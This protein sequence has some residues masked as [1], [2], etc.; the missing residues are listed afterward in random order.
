MLVS[1]ELYL[2]E[3]DF[4]SQH[5]S[6]CDLLIK[7]TGTQ[8]IYAI[9][10]QLHDRIKILA[11]HRIQNTDEL[12]ALLDSDALFNY[13][14]RKVK[15]ALYTKKFTFIPHEVY[16]VNNLSAYSKF[17]QAKPETVSVIPVKQ[18]AI[19]N[20][21]DLSHPFRELLQEKFPQARF[22][23][24]V[25]TLIEPA[26]KHLQKEDGTYLHLHINQHNLELLATRNKQVLLYNVYPAA[27]PDEFNYFLLLAIQ[28]LNLSETDTEVTL[29]GQVD[30]QDEWYSR[31]QKYFHHIRFAGWNEMIHIP[32]LFNEIPAHR[33]FT[34]AGLNECE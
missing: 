22:Y 11:E 2:A 18:A 12:K 31:V 9:I 3:E 15:I 20:V 34:L 29:S 7:I 13:Y 14:Y 28:Q 25:E 32:E 21:T 19:R 26:I 5:S 30:E 23:S 8:C 4:K 27:T 10:D 17:I 16:N 1:K 24:Q 33:Y 6:K